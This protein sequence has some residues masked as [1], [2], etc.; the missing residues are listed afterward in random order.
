[1]D[2]VDTESSLD[3]PSSAHGNTACPTT[4]AGLA[5]GGGSYRCPGRFFAEMEVS[6]IVQLLLWRYSLRLV[7]E[8][9]A[10]PGR[11]EGPPLST[12]GGGGGDGW[13]GAGARAVL[14]DEAAVWG[15]GLLERQQG[16]QTQAAGAAAGQADA[17]SSGESGGGGGGDSGGGGSGAPSLPTWCDSGDPSS[18]LP[19]ADLHRLVGVKLPAEP[20]MVTVAQRVR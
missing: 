14:G 13:V 15:L 2:F 17:G 19:R 16:K 6:L 3:R 4:N 12:E 5:F 9:D 7:S 1:M 18:L 20:C 10:A 11:A 8:R